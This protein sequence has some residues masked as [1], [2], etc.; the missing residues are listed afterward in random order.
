ME[1][2]L[3]PHLDDAVRM[4]DDNYATPADIDTAMRLG[5]G[6]PRG[7]FELLAEIGPKVVADGLMRMGRRPSPLLLELPTTE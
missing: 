6:Y 7:P 3:Y 5:C 2:L 1:S 4:A